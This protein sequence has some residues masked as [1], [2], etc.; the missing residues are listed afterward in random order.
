MIDPTPQVRKLAE[1]ELYRAEIE[2]RRLARR[3]FLA[4]IAVFIAFE[5][6]PTR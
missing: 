3:L 6:P 1:A 2:A 4:G 5:I